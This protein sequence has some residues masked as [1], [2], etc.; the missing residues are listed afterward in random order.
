MRLPSTGEDS[1]AMRVM[2]RLATWP[3][4][5]CTRADCGVGQAVA[6]GGTQIAHLHHANTIELRLGRPAIA[7][8][9]KTLVA[10][11]QVA[12]R[13]ETGAGKDWV[14]VPLQAPSDENLAIALASL[15]IRA[16][17]DLSPQG[18]DQRSSGCRLTGRGRISGSITG[19]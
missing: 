16:V 8:M 17:S 10:S 11:G 3:E 14:V 2:S 13:S 4:I 18:R 1:P 15:A 6:V 19:L 5:V 12:I 7:R 9:G